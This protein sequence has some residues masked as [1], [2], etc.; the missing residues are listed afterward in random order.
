MPGI[1]ARKC[2]GLQTELINKYIAVKRE[3]HKQ[4]PFA[5]FL[6]QMPKAEKGK[7]AE[8]MAQNYKPRLDARHIPYAREPSSWY[9]ASLNW[10]L[11]FICFRYA[12]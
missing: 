4:Q 9:S 6:E 2:R 1:S 3:S 11:D 12:D 5:R 10:C 7:L 8:R